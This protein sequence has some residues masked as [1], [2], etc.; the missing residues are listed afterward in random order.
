MYWRCPVSVTVS[1]EVHR[2]DGLGLG[3]QEAGPGD[4]RPLRRR[5]DALGLE[6][7]PDRGGSNLDAE[8][9]EF[10]VDTAVPPGGV[11]GCQ[12]QDGAAD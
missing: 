10:A 6:D 11:F 7:L 3:A 12:A 9:G 1:S 4:G 5:I 2:Q 8:E